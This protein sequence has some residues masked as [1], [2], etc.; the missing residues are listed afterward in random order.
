MERLSEKWN[1]CESL[2]FH[3][4][5]EFITCMFYWL[6]FIPRPSN[7]FSHLQ[8][9]LKEKPR[10]NC[11]S[12]MPMLGYLAWHMW[13]KPLLPMLPAKFVFNCYY[14]VLFYIFNSYIRPDLLCLQLPSAATTLCLTLRYSMIV[15]LK[16]LKTLVQLLKLII[17]LSGGTSNS[18][19]GLKFTVNCL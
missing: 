2:L 9:L 5:F 15:S 6:Y 1:T 19:F 12:V 14:A 7:I 3:F 10:Q 4:G 8:V 13:P 16:L 11:N 18:S 17:W